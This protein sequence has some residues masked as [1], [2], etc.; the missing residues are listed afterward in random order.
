MNK[1]EFEGELMHIEPN[2]LINKDKDDSLANFFLVL[3]LIYNDLKDI[4]FFHKMLQ[5][6]YVIPSSDKATFHNGEYSGVVIHVNKLLA[7]HMHE[8]FIFLKK[9]EETLDSPEFISVLNSMDNKSVT[10]AWNEIVNIAME[11]EVMNNRFTNDLVQIR[12]N[13]AFHYSQSGK[14]LV[15][16]FR[17]YFFNSEKMAGNDQAYYALGQNMASSR[18]FYADATVQEYVRNKVSGY[19]KED[20][21]S[22]SSVDFKSRMNNTIEATNVTILRLLKAYLRHRPK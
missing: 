14:E 15:K 20:Y 13:V 18:F 12:N 10:G 21:G 1:I 6:Q 22:E 4:I 8:F 5:D 3:S 2:R 19:S 7:S 17:S 16:A 9:N 11:R